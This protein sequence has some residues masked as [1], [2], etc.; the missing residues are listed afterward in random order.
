MTTSTLSDRYITTTLA[1]L[2]RQTQETIEED[3]RGT[4]AANIMRR[5]GHGENHDTAEYATLVTLGNPVALATRYV[6]G[7][8]ALISPRV[9][10]SWSLAARWTCATVLPCLYLILVIL[11][12]VNQDNIW[13]TIFRPAGITLT[14]GAYLLA[15]VTALYA[16]IDR[17]SDAHDQATRW[18]PDQLDDE[19]A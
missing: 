3:L 16:L 18:T 13:I 12:A 11:Y 15:A 6:G 1:H 17:Q 4:I 8:D 5:V 10:S 2:P 7:N 9:Y 14:V 19:H